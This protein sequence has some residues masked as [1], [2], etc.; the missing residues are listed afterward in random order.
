MLILLC[1]VQAQAKPQFSGEFQLSERNIDV[2]MAIACSSYANVETPIKSEFL[3]HSWTTKKEAGRYTSKGICGASPGSQWRK[4][5]PASIEISIS[6]AEFLKPDFSFILGHVGSSGFKFYISH[7]SV[8]H[9]GTLMTGSFL[10]KMTIFALGLLSG[11]TIIDSNAASKSFAIYEKF[12]SKELVFTSQWGP[13]I[14]I[15]GIGASWLQAVNLWNQGRDLFVNSPVLTSY[16][17]R[18]EGGSGDFR[19]QASFFYSGETLYGCSNFQDIYSGKDM[20]SRKKCQ[21]IWKNSKI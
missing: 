2:L 19:A 8:F 18:G 12:A 5:K 14:D 13:N 16:L 20:I 10:D 4:P 9:Q 11:K 6:E 15:E 3:L 7:K 17:T 21:D 1:A